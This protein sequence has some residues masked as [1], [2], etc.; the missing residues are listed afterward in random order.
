MGGLRPGRFS[1]RTSRSSLAG[2]AGADALEGGAGCLAVDAV[3]HRHQARDPLAV[4][5]DHDFLAMLDQIE[6]L[7][8]F[9]SQ[10]WLSIAETQA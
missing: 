7:A 2:G 5:G 4:A 8:E 6:Q 3:P 9:F 1:I 10:C